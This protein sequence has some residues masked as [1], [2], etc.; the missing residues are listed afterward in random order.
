MASVSAFLSVMEEFIQE[1]KETFPEE[2]AIAT[3]QE[4]F[5]KRKDKKGKK[6]LDNFMNDVSLIADVI[7]NQNEEKLL[8]SDCN[9]IKEIGILNVWNDDMDDD[10]KQAI[11][12]YLN[13]MYVLGTTIKSIPTNLLSQI[14]MMAEQCVKDMPNNSS[15]DDN[16]AIP[17]MSSL[18]AGMQNMMQGMAKPKRHR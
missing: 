8:A 13:T 15:G 11:W 9:F 5:L 10:V 17:D 12:K 3:F 7:T 18:M 14:E 2:P 1:M 4:T 6:I 16:I